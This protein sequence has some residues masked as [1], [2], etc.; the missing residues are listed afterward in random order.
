[1]ELDSEVE[2]RLEQKRT[3]IKMEVEGAELE[4]IRMKLGL[5]ELRHVGRELTV[6]EMELRLE[7]TE[8]EKNR[9]EWEKRGK[10]L[11]KKKIELEQRRKMWEA[12][13]MWLKEKRM[14]WDSEFEKLRN[15]EDE[16]ELKTKHLKVTKR[17]MK[18]EQL[19]SNIFVVEPK[20]MK[21]GWDETTPATRTAS[22]R[23]VVTQ[24]IFVMGGRG[25][26]RK[27]LGSVEKYVFH[28]GKW[29]LLPEMNTPRSFMSSVFVGNEIVVSGGDTGLEV[30][31]TIE[32]LNFDETPPQWIT[33]SA[34]LPVPLSGHQTVVYQG[35]LIAIG[36]HNGS[37]GFNSDKIYEVC[38][39]PPYSTNILCFMPQPRAGHGAELIGDEIFIFGGTK[40][41]FAP[42]DDVLVYNLVTREFRVMKSL[43]Y[44]VHGMA[45]VR[46]S[47]I[48]I[49]LGGIDHNG[50]ELD[51]VITYN[52]QSGEIN[53]LPS[54]KEKRG[55][56]CAVR[57]VMP[58][59]IAGCSSDET[60]EVLVALGSLRD[61]KTTE[62]YDFR[63]KRWKGMP[64]LIFPRKYSTMVAS[65]REF[66]FV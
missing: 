56:C 12:K 37:E 45:T 34:K 43:P 26:D 21:V 10:E 64:S 31:D 9:V 33:S 3:E 23:S 66:N 22:S 50:E 27:I 55:S 6:N 29:V 8:L 62:Y 42:N 40:N 11:E 4:Q 28:D 39:T 57:S 2:K 61:I 35:K 36:G 15:R 52:I 30:T 13:A 44:A 53:S 1:M 65:P 18:S 19:E 17:R 49:L 60:T 63:S 16:L 54:M 47:G 7:E 24:D 20:R 25:E 14:E 58:D 5:Q 46:Q 51:R 38:L 32:T 59:S 41:V 48:V